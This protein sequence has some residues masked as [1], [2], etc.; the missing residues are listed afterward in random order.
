MELVKVLAALQPVGLTLLFEIFNIWLQIIMLS[1]LKTS[2]ACIICP[3]KDQS[4]EFNGTS[5][6]NIAE[7][8]ACQTLLV[9][10]ANV[11]GGKKL[12]SACLSLIDVEI[13]SSIKWERSLLRN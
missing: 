11:L 3:R 13:S 12:E 6:E 4:L 5:T 2:I 1:A 10:V 8:H 9:I 7:Y